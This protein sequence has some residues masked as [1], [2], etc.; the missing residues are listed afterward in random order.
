MASPESSS[1]QDPERSFPSGILLCVLS[2]V[3]AV[4]YVSGKLPQIDTIFRTCGH[5]LHVAYV[6]IADILLSINAKVASFFNFHIR[7]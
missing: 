3:L 6:F 4:L 1:S 7:V 5:C 2:L